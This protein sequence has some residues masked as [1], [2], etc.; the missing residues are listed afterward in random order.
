M[1]W[2]KSQSVVK[3][4]LYTAAGF[5]KRVVV[6]RV[7][8]Q[9]AKQVST[10]ARA[11]AASGALPESGAGQGGPATPKPETQN[12]EPEIRN[13]ILKPET[14]NLKPGSLKPEPKFWNLKP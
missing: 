10:A 4:I 7:V 8:S 5:D 12:P 11:K 14:Q 3:R 9:S 13:L 1:S 2:S 6:L